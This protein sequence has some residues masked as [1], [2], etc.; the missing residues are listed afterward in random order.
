MELVEKGYYLAVLVNHK[1]LT[2]T[3]I[4]NTME[5]LVY[6]VDKILILSLP[7]SWYMCYI[8]HEDL[9]K[10]NKMIEIQEQKELI[11]NKQKEI[12]LNKINEFNS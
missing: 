9:K 4:K 2:K 11:L 8:M 10:K 5:Q 1:L 6:W 3:Y 7:F 12:L